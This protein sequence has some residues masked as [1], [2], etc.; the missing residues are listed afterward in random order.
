[1]TKRWKTGYKVVFKDGN[2]L[3]SFIGWQDKL[4]SLS[5]E[6]SVC[7][8]EIGKITE[9]PEG[10]GPLC[11]FSTFKEA[12]WFCKGV[13]VLKICKCRYKESQDNALWL[14]EY[15]GVRD[16]FYPHFNTKFADKVKLIQFIPKKTKISL[17]G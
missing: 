14:V 8:Y 13:R 10:G 3:K 5:Q 1:M 9:R 15:H 17:E 12:L 4:L 7:F 2:I 16:K 11:L 6:K